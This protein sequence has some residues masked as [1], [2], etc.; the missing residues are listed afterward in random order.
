M[1]RRR[2]NP[3]V[4]GRILVS[5]I[6]ASFLNGCAAR[7]GGSLPPLE[8]ELIPEATEFSLSGRRE[9]NA[10]FRA[11]NRSR[12]PVRLDFPT[13]QNFEV[14]LFGRTD[15]P[16]HLWSEDRLFSSS[17]SQVVV[18]PG[19]RLELRFTLPTRDMVPGGIY[20]VEAALPGYPE[21]ERAVELR[22]R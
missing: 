10:V 1:G 15:A 12:Q 8:S 11:A 5:L 6:F 22:P 7:D 17:P 4:P 13:G 19:E 21:T 18:N 9:L 3:P 14:K 2:F 16:L 20:R